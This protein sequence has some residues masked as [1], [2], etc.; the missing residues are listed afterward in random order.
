MRV[1]LANILII[2]A[3]L[4]LVLVVTL[5]IVRLAR[6]YHARALRYH[7]APALVMPLSTPPSRTTQPHAAREAGYLRLEQTTAALAP[8]LEVFPPGDPRA[9]HAGAEAL[10]AQA[11]D[12][13]ALDANGQAAERDDD[14]SRRS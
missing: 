14:A 7:K 1:S 4:S 2:V 3:A 13:Q 12:A 11:M 10:D 5:A 9:H 6:H 8:E